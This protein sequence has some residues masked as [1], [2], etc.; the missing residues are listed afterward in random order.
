MQGGPQAGE[1]PESA[2]ASS[3][4]LCATHMVPRL[5]C[6]VSVQWKILRGSQQTHVTG[7][8]V[9]ISAVGHFSSF[10]PISL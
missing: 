3:P 9:P 10:P 2:S 5:E 4:S 7:I 8:D 1:Q 6:F